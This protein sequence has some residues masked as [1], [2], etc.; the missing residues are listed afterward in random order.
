MSEPV[1][2]F[3]QYLSKALVGTFFQGMLCFMSL[4]KEGRLKRDCR[5]AFM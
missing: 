2:L 4:E 1:S 5:I 3:L